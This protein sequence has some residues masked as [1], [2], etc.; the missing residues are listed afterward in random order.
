M[1]AYVFWHWKRTGIQSKEYEDRLSKFHRALAAAPPNGFT[2]SWSAA[3]SNAPWANEGLD[4]YEDW[5]CVQGSEVL[6]VLEE[7]AISASRKVPHDQAAS[8]AKGGTAGLYRLRA[9]REF[10]SPKHAYWF[11]KPDGWSYEQLYDSLRAITSS[12]DAA[13][14][15]RQMTLGPAREFCLHTNSDLKL[16]KGINAQSIAPRAVFPEGA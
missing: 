3:L 7:A 11:A 1:L 16:P 14:W 13:L 4:A 2:Q 5:Y 15:G 9:G 10:R 12:S 8:L 6:D